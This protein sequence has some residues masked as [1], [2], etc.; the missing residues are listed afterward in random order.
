MISRRTKTPN[1]NVISSQ[2]SCG[3]IQISLKKFQRPSLYKIPK[4]NHGR[5]G[6]TDGIS[7]IANFKEFEEK[8]QRPEKRAKGNTIKKA[9]MPAK[10]LLIFNIL[11]SIS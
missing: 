10:G 3:S 6:I 7:Q 11:N 5:E 8:V 9:I 4:D 1:I 2:Y